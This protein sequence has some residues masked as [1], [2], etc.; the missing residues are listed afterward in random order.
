MIQRLDLKM[1]NPLILSLDI[2]TSSARALLFTP[3]GSQVPQVGTRQEYQ[4]QA[5]QDGSVTLD[6]DWLVETVCKLVDNALEQPRESQ[7]EI[8]G[9]A[10]STFATST[11]GLDSGWKLVTP[12]MTYADS[13]AAGAAGQLR[14]RLDEA[15]VHQRTGTLFHPSYW[16]ARIAWLGATDPEL[17]SRVSHWMTIGEYLIWRLFGETAVSNSAAAW[18]GL[19]DIHRCDWDAPLL[20]ALPVRRDQLSPIVNRDHAWQGLR[21]E[22]ARRWPALAGAKWFPAVGDGT[23][24]NVGSGCVSSGELAVVMGTSSAVRITLENPVPEIPPGLWCYRIDADH[25]LLGGAMNEGGVI[26]AWAKNLLRLDETGDL[27]QAAASLPPD[28]HGL[29][30]LPLLAGERSPGWRGEARGGLYG[31]SLATTPLQVLRAGMEAVCYRIAL[32]Y[33]LIRKGLP[34]DPTIIASGG[35]LQRSPAWVQ[36]LADVLGQPI[37]VSSA[38]EP[39]A[40]GGALLAAESLGLLRGLEAAPRELG[41]TF[42]PASENYEIYQRAIQRQ[43]ELY[44]KLVVEP[45]E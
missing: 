9:V 43:Q 27:D 28:G 15:A 22:Y 18:T 17:L 34:G 35:G 1:K 24:S 11:I 7:A 37:R 21:P 30:F 3:T 41:A 32:I 16:P 20:D 10:C 42:Q 40:R 19:E 45:W 31:L 13:R 25:P 12:L 38:L 44:Q 29:T 23:A 26:Y 6:P 5:G 39:T 8:A 33:Q 14:A 36:I 4:P 2:G